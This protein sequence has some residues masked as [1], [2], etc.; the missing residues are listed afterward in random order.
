MMLNLSFSCLHL[1]KHVVP[2]AAAAEMAAAAAAAEMVAAAAA[3]I[4]VA[5]TDGLVAAE[6]DSVVSANGA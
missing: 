3:A 5:G 2:C 1:E 6:I 4:A